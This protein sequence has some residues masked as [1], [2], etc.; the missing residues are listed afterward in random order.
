MGS[1]RTMSRDSGER[2]LDDLSRRLNRAG[3]G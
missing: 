3:S 1:G 2:T